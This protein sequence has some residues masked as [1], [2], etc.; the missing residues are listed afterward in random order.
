[1]DKHTHEVADTPETCIR[2]HEAQTQ[3]AQ[4]FE[5]VDQATELPML[6]LALVFAVVVMLLALAELPS[7]ADQALEAV[8]WLIWGVFVFELLV[9]TYLAPDRRRYLVTHWADVLSVLVPALRPLRFLRLVVAGVR[10]W[11][12]AEE[13]LRHRAFSFLALTTLCAVV[14]A[15]VLVYAVERQGDG[16]I[17]T[18]ADAFWW[19]AATI[20]TV[21]YGDVYPRT[22]AGR[23]IAVVLMLIGISLFGVL[24][25]RVAAFFVQGAN[26]EVDDDKLDEI[27]ARLQRLEQLLEHKQ[28]SGTDDRIQPSPDGVAPADTATPAR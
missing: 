24:T 16:P 9:K 23:G 6:V 12:N 8:T 10:F 15:G 1:M 2:E 22:P 20:T 14:A 26:R 27:R 18:L 5:R 19:A 4:L 21:G 25:A 7:D 28:A 3:R 17:Q 13:L 11:R